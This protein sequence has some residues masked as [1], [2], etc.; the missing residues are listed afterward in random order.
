LLLRRLALGLHPR[1][2]HLL[3]ATVLLPPH[4]HGACDFVRV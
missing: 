2:R 1:L 4:W 3:L